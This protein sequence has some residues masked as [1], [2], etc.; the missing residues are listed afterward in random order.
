MFVFGVYT[1]ACMSVCVYNCLGSQRLS[2]PEFDEGTAV[3]PKGGWGLFLCLPR[4]RL[5]FVVLFCGFIL[6]R[7]MSVC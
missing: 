2:E 1:C 4:T 7:G 5:I 3:V 6:R